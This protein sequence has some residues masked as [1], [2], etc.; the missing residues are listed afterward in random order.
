Y[1]QHKTG[2]MH[3]VI[4]I[5]GG[6]SGLQ[7]GVMTAKAGEDTLVL[8][9]GESLVHNTANIQNLVGHES[10]SG[11]ALLKKGRE[12][13]EDFN[14][15]LREER[16]EKVERTDEGFLVETEEDDYNSEYVVIASA[17]IHDYLELDLEFEEG[18]E[19][20]YW[21]DE[22]IVT[23]ENNRAA[24]G[25]YAAGL[26]RLWEYQVAVALGD[27]AKAAVDLL[28]DKYGEPYQDHDT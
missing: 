17:G 9:T 22:H 7:A 27:G 21:M 11:K 19:G 8:D 10:V 26:A 6:I 12:K 13:L 5:G 14:G 23:D 2:F 3:T 25:V 16:V 20:P 1:F 18:A 28:S 4:V 15:E 24:E